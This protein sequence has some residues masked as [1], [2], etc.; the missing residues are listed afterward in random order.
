VSKFISRNWVYLISPI[1]VD[2]LLRGIHKGGPD[3]FHE[4]KR[5]LGAVYPVGPKLFLPAPADYVAYYIFGKSSD[6]LHQG[7]QRDAIIRAFLQIR[8]R[9]EVSTKRILFGSRETAL[10]YLQGINRWY[11]ERYNAYA[12]DYESVRNKGV[13]V[14]KEEWARHHLSNL[15][16]LNTPENRK[17]ILEAL[18]ASY[19]LS[20][21]GIQA[22]R[23][24]GYDFFKHS[25]AI[26][27]NQQL[28]YLCDP[29]IHFV[30]NDKKLKTHCQPSPQVSRIWTWPELRSAAKC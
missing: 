24:K 15:G 16:A 26:A 9:S 6:V 23:D 13:S 4:S 22:M 19:H 10:S 21:F 12:T 1:T 3:K 27:D 8:D 14:G 5:A 17:T 29:A 28:S 25:S 2:E 18:S 11:L 7:P 30:T 20:Q